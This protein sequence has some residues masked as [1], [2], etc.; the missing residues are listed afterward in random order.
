VKPIKP[1]IQGN[2]K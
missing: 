2:P 1:D